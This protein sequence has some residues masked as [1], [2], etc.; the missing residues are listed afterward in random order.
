MRADR[1]PCFS[2]FCADRLFPSALLGP[3]D[4]SQGRQRLIR[5]AWRALRF[6]VQPAGWPYNSTMD[7]TAIADVPRQ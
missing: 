1:S 6:F 7:L 5:E 2:E 4:F 3:V